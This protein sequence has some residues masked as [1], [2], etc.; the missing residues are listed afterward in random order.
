MGWRRGELHII[1]G[2]PNDLKVMGPATHYVEVREDSVEV[3]R[4]HRLNSVLIHEIQQVV[5]AW[6]RRYAW[7][8]EAKEELLAIL[9]WL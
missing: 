9:S 6:A 7:I 3:C 1:S 2:C 5:V 4:E 8:D